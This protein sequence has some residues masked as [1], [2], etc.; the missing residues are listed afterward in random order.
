MENWLELAILSFLI[1]TLDP[2]DET[3]KRY[4]RLSESSYSLLN[5]LRIKHKKVGLSG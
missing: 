4:Y 5:V 3:P 2:N 1:F